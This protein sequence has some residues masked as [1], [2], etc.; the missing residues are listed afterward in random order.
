MR[1]EPSLEGLA[2]VETGPG[3]GE[4]SSGVVSLWE[5]MV[6]VRQSDEGASVEGLES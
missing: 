4:A 2:A 5:A 6:G 1:N 3:G